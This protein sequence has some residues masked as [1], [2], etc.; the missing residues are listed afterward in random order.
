MLELGV[1]N[2]GQTEA[3]VEILGPDGADAGFR[4]VVGPSGGI[5]VSAE[6]PGPGGWT[7]TVNGQPVTDWRD[8][9]DDNPVIDLSLVI[10]PDGSVDVLDT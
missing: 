1:E 4:E 6:R 10:N 7:V 8:W 9:P 3:V 2:L 5:E